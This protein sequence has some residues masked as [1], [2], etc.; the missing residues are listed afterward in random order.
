[1]ARIKG[2]IKKRKEEEETIVQKRIKELQKLSE[3]F[4]QKRI[5]ELNKK[6]DTKGVISDKEMEYFQKLLSKRSK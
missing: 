3:T 5:K 1:M 6:A 2:G 4:I